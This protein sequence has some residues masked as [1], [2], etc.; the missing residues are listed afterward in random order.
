MTLSPFVLHSFT[1]CVIDPKALVKQSCKSSQLVAPDCMYL[2]Q[3]A[4]L[5]DVHTYCL[6]AYLLR[7]QFR[8]QCHATSCIKRACWGKIRDKYSSGGIVSFFFNKSLP[9]LVLYILLKNKKILNVR[10]LIN[11]FAICTQMRWNFSGNAGM[12]VLQLSFCEANFTWSHDVSC[13]NL[14]N[15]PVCG[16]INKSALYI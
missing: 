3:L 1:L 11:F 12:H 7:I 10:S 2:W 14:Q 6:C 5:K 13:K 8:L 9:L 16:E 4:M 15:R